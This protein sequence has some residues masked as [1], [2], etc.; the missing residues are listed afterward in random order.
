MQATLERH[1]STIPPEVGADSSEVIAPLT[2]FER[3][4]RGAIEMPPED[5]TRG[6]ELYWQHADAFRQRQVANAQPWFH[7]VDYEAEAIEDTNLALQVVDWTY[8][9]RGTDFPADIEIHY[10]DLSD[11]KGYSDK[12]EF[13]FSFDGEP[14]SLAR[15][16]RSDDRNRII[17]ELFS[18]VNHDP[19]L[20][21]LLTERESRVAELVRDEL[22]NTPFIRYIQTISQPHRVADA[23][24]SVAQIR[25]RMAQNE[26]D[27]RRRFDLGDDRHAL[28]LEPAAK[29]Y[30]TK[31]NMRLED[32]R[33]A[34]PVH[35]KA[36]DAFTDWVSGVALTVARNSGLT[37]LE[38]Y[39]VS[40][41]EDH[42]AKRFIHP[43]LFL[44]K[45][46][47]VNGT[48]VTHEFFDEV[49]NN[50][51]GFEHNPRG[52]LQLERIVLPFLVKYANGDNEDFI[53]LAL[54]DATEF[55]THRL[56]GAGWILGHNHG[57]SMQ[58]VAFA[59][60][61]YR[62]HLE[63]SEVPSTGDGQLRSAGLIGNTIDRLTSADPGRIT[64]REIAE[65]LMAQE[66]GRVELR[67]GKI[68]ERQLVMFPDAY[69]TDVNTLPKD[70]DSVNLDGTVV[71]YSPLAG[72]SLQMPG[73][74]AQAHMRGVWVI[75]QGGESPYTAADH[76]VF[77]LVNNTQV[78]TD[79]KSIGFTELAARLQGKQ[80]L[81]AREI[82]RLV[83]SQMR[84]TYDTS[85]KPTNS[86]EDN[87]FAQYKG[88]IKNGRLMGQCDT[89]AAFT[90]DLINALSPD[91]VRASVISGHLVH[92]DGTVTAMGHAQTRITSMH[93]SVKEA[94]ID[95]TPAE[96]YVAPPSIA[97]LLFRVNGVPDSMPVNEVVLDTAR[98]DRTKE[99][100]VAY[101]GQ[102]DFKQ[103]AKLML[104]LQESDPLRQVYRVAV[105][106][107]EQRES[108]TS[109]EVEAARS[110]LL[111][112]RTA[113]PGKIRA[114]G[115][116]RYPEYLIE[117]LLELL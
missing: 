107:V 11:E 43:H 77:A 91:G 55:I 84:Y 24:L 104:K 106:R 79:L 5:V 2:D 34:R 32:E 35:T 63:L 64:G 83:R 86:S 15:I 61:L 110:Y 113:K 29:N 89:A 66:V 22:G 47:V 87:P 52:G 20:A 101:F 3:K 95:A 58:S 62:D 41:E 28:A 103:T 38:K 10:H 96:E 73:Y 71:V 94:I 99:L 9:G 112:Y 30:L 27:T 16:T 48:D 18:V 4:V 116:P 46:D 115:L 54:D 45:T 25:M 80:T 57:A 69:N 82:E 65:Q 36:A 97:Q 50:F 92:S 42:D 81:D 109:Q 33:V 111:A 78:I 12:S 108:V 98:L 23:A 26:Q 72:Q 13:D 100:L 1:P 7:G 21:D 93:G 76:F 67:T 56:I 68:I 40:I 85:L 37:K 117:S 70:H 60:Q 31:L 105:R 53:E 17:R 75:E 88:Y 19:A 14:A 8:F 102:H 90:A 39:D 74:G 44:H 59:M 49:G 114:S 6:R 51:P